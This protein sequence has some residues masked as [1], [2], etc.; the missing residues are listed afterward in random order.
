M[1]RK[2]KPLLLPHLADSPKRFDAMLTAL[3]AVKKDELQ[4][5]EDKIKQVREAKE[6]RKQAARPESDAK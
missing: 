4:R 3:L 6:Q 2:P 1:P 5:V